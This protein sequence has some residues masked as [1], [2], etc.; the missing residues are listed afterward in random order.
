[1]RH[2]T[3]RPVYSTAVRLLSSHR[4]CHSVEARE[5]VAQL[6]GASSSQVWADAPT[7]TGCEACDPRQ[8]EI[9]YT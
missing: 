3:F 8:R 9:P 1:M 4:W 6:Y 5:L 2:G 7:C